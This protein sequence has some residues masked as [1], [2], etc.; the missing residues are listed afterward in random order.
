MIN[1]LEARS[2]NKKV[3]LGKNNELH[4]LK[5]VTLTIEKGEFV[6][7]KIGRAHV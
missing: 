1:I 7:V 6:S 2:M 4:I 5:D 3:E